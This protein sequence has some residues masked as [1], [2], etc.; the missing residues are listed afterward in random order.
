M[1]VTDEPTRVAIF[2][3]DGITALDLAQSGNPPALLG[4]CPS[5]TY[6]EIDMENSL[7]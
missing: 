1:N 3:F 2:A 7:P 6:S 4:D 5:F